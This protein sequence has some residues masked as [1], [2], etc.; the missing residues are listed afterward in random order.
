MKVKPETYKNLIA[1]DKKGIHSI[2][3]KIV[4]KVFSKE[5]QEKNLTDDSICIVCN[6][7]FK[8]KKVDWSSK[9]KAIC[10]PFRDDSIFPSHIKRYLFSESDFCDKMITPTKNCSWE[11]S[12]YKY[13]FIYFTLNNKEGTR[14]KGIYLISLLD[15]VADSLNLNGLVVDYS[16]KETSKHKATIYEESLKKVRKIIPSL[17]RIV[18]LKKHLTSSE[19]C[20]AMNGAKFVF[21]PSDADASPRLLTEAL[22]RD[23][24]LVVNSHI[25]GGWKYI[26]DTN[27]VFFNAPTV[28]DF[29]ND[30]VTDFHFSSLKMSIEKV[31]RIDCSK[32]S[33]KYYELYGFKNASK[34]LSRIIN[35]ITG[36]KYRA[37][38]YKE[39]KN[40][41]K[42]LA[43]QEN[44][45]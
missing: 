5:N 38:A 41:L 12:N 20:A 28:E 15:K 1:I 22:V 21:L 42:K 23:K 17:K 34:E 10:H 45:I 43:K 26:N 19:V 36:K 35:K 44:W 11:Y 33:G 16:V 14:S 9:V 8:E 30:R 3:N 37:V 24:P 29:L 2:P 25:Y 18:V 39:W 6:F 13:D 27:G 4:R 40:T 32:I 31:L 7:R